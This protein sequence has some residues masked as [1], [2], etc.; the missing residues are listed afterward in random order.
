MP[1][2]AIASMTMMRAV[3][4]PIF[5]H[6]LAAVEPKTASTAGARTTTTEIVPTT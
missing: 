2:T 1:A 4:M 6:A 5:G 3:L